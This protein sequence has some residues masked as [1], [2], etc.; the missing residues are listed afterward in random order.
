LGRSC[1]KFKVLYRAEE[2]RNILPKTDTRTATWIGHILCRNRLLKHAIEGKTEGRIEVTERRGKEG[3]SYWTTLR[4]ETILA[5]EKENTRSHSV[6][7]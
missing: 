4:K 2:E 6:E 5:I 3:S 1:E 7:N